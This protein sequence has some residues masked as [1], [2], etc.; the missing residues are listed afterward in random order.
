MV[1]IDTFATKKNTSKELTKNVS[2]S[3]NV[4]QIN[5]QKESILETRGK[6]HQKEL[7]YCE[8]KNQNNVD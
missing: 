3:V 5:N 6:E 2:I 4:D 7:E 8:H 1:K